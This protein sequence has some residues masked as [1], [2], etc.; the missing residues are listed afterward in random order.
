MPPYTYGSQYQQYPQYGHTGPPFDEFDG[1]KVGVS[2]PEQGGQPQG[3]DPTWAG[4][5][6][7]QGG[8]MP[9]PGRSEEGMH[10]AGPAQSG[11]IG[12]EGAPKPDAP[13]GD[14][15]LNAAAR[16]YGNAR[17]SVVS[18]GAGFPGAFQ[19]QYAAG[20]GPAVPPAGYETAQPWDY[21]ASAFQGHH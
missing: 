16:L 21:S 12:S 7:M 3:F 19:P 10:Q 1:S 5:A 17:P 15:R 4:A 13:A 14:D 20:S 9:G 11:V 2:Y 8:P 6:P 18:A